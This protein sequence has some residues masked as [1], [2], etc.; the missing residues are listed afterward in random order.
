MAEQSCVP[1]SPGVREG[2]RRLEQDV[3]PKNRESFLPIPLGPVSRH[4]NCFPKRRHVRSPG[5]IQ[6]VEEVVFL[7][8]QITVQCTVSP[9]SALLAA[10]LSHSLLLLFSVVYISVPCA[11]VFIT[12]VSALYPDQKRV[13]DSLEVVTDASELPCGCREL[14]PGSLQEQPVTPTTKLPLLTYK[15]L[16]ELLQIQPIT[17]VVSI[18][19]QIIQIV[20]FLYFP[21]SL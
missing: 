1:Q 14:N 21:V 8:I 4:L 16:E 3:D 11:L 20:L 17:E 2:R 5:V 6:S 15:F 19:Y 13:S 9:A 12:R 10:K 7:V 18:Y